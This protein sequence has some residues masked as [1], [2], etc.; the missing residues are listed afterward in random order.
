MPISYGLVTLFKANGYYRL[1]WC[2]NTFDDNLD[3]WGPIYKFQS[4]WNWTPEP[5]VHCHYVELR[6]TTRPQSLNTFVALHVFMALIIPS[7]DKLWGLP[8]RVFTLLS[9][10]PNTVLQSHPYKYGHAHIIRY[11]PGFLPRFHSEFARIFAKKIIRIFLR[12]W[13]QMKN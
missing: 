4:Y 3:V 7:H 8:R 10:L 6:T 13:A 11:I 1:W 5:I 12:K 2:F 9:C